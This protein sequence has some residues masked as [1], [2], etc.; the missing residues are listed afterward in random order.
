MHISPGSPNFERDCASG[1]AS[2][3]TPKLSQELEPHTRTRAASIHPLVTIGIP[4]RNR[5]SIVGD[6]TKRALA[7]TYSNIEVLVSD[8]GSTDDTVAT[9]RSIAD[10]R[11]R[12]LTS[13]EDIGLCANHSKCI[14]EAEGEFLLLVPD[15]DSI[16]ETFIKRA[17]DLLRVEQGIQAVVGAYGVFF[18]DESRDRPAI[19]S[20]RLFTGIWDGSEIFKECLRGQLSATMLST[21][22]RTELLRSIG[23]PTEYQAADDLLTMGRILLS[24]RVG[25]L[26]ERCAT[27]AIHDRSRSNRLGLDSHFRE[28]QEVMEVFSDIATRAIRDEAGRRELQELTARY[29]AKKLFDCLVL[30]RRQGGTLREVARQFRIWGAQSH[31]CTMIDFVAV[32]QLK[33]LTLLLL[34]SSITKLLLSL[35]RAAQGIFVSAHDRAKNYAVIGEPTVMKEN[36]SEERI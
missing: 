33:T 6:A 23:W 25:L 28:T 14:R 20:K 12:I 10:S 16:S 19:I 13:P 36:R 15:D 1:E 5:A 11:L 30:Y 24:G 2:L 32:L 34:P 9:L 3:S 8:N 35:R 7:Q 26:N 27:L 18:A 4:T 21:V 31:Q 29:A 22:V 17:V